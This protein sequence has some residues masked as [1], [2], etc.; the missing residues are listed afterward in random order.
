MTPKIVLLGEHDK[1]KGFPF[2]LSTLSGRRIRAM[3]SEI[4]LDCQFDNAF[5]WD[6]LRKEKDIRY[7]IGSTVVALGKAAERECNRQGVECIYLPHPACRSKAQ[8][9]SLREGLLRLPNR[10]LL[11]QKLYCLD[12]DEELEIVESGLS[13]QIITAVCSDC[14]QSW[15]GLRENVE[16]LLTPRKPATGRK[17]WQKM[18]C[19][20]DWHDGPFYIMVARSHEEPDFYPPSSMFKVE[21]CTNCGLLR[22]PQELR[23][24]IGKNL[25]G[26]TLDAPD[27]GNHCGKINKKE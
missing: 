15:H 9:E 27:K 17:V 16:R 1:G 4:G 8:L 21:H 3:V 10:R 24:Y 23:K 22:L 14:K 20:H 26:L 13:S 11:M 12:C 6:G 2:H 5:S 25:S 18:D 19:K 7:L